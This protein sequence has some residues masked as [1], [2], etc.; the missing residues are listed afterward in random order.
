MLLYLLSLS[1]SFEHC[2]DKFDQHEIDEI[3]EYLQ[4]HNN[5]NLPKVLGRMNNFKLILSKVGSTLKDDQKVTTRSSGRV[6]ARRKKNV[7]AIVLYEIP[8]H[9]N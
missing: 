3:G 8:D 6:K 4:A 2:P 7:N 9:Q 1:H 5:A